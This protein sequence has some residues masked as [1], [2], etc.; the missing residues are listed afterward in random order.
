MGFY[1]V[2]FKNFSLSEKIK[3]QPELLFSTQGTKTVAEG[4][5]IFNLDNGIVSSGNFEYQIKEY[6]VSLPIYYNIYY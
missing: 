1:I 2:G 6:T 4:I 3:I 5:E